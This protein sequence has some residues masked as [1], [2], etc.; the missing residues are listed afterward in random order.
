MPVQHFHLRTICIKWRKWS[1]QEKNPLSQVVK[2]L[3]ELENAPS[4]MNLAKF[5]KTSIYTNKPD[6]AFF[7]E[8]SSR[9]E[10]VA[11]THQKDDDGNQKML[12]RV[13]NR[14]ESDFSEPCDSRIIG[15]YR[16]NTTSSAM[17][18][19]TKEDLQTK[20]MMV[21]NRGGRHAKALAILHELWTLR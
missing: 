7:L 16:I 18:F 19:L 17:K 5:K 8:D 11:L 20:A 1:D 9:C 2:R 21:D 6:N 4:E 10:V 12:C 14:T 15:V 3:H 13:Y